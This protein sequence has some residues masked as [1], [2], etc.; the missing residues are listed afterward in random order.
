MNLYVN[1]LDQEECKKRYMETKITEHIESKGYLTHW[2]G[3][4]RNNFSYGS[5]LSRPRRYIGWLDCWKDLFNYGYNRDTFTISIEINSQ[6]ELDKITPIIKEVFDI[7]GVTVN[8][9]KN[10][11]TYKE[12]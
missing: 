4:Y 10:Y 8:I 9:N 2:C 12:D 7:K 11:C 1:P 5:T 6:E 3:L